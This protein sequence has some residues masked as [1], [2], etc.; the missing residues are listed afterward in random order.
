MSTISRVHTMSTE[1]VHSYYHGKVKVKVKIEDG[2]TEGISQV[3][4]PGLFR[5]TC[6]IHSYTL[7]NMQKYIHLQSVHS[8]FLLEFY[9]QNDMEGK[10]THTHTQFFN[11]MLTI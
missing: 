10:H 8:F 9:Y 4:A 3:S 11:R 7:I 1:D 6:N 2:P 5:H